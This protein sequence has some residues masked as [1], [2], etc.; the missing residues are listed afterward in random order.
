[1]RANWLVLVLLAA[2][3]FGALTLIEHVNPKA[4]WVAAL[5]GGAGL[6]I[7]LTLSRKDK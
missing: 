5:A 6:S 4:A 3:A 7:Y 1:M 2:I